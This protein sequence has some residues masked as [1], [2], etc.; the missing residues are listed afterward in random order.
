LAQ[1]N[2]EL[3]QAEAPQPNVISSIQQQR[4]QPDVIGGMEKQHQQPVGQ[5]NGSD[6]HHHL[7]VAGGG[8]QL[9]AEDVGH[10]SCTAAVLHLKQ[11]LPV[12]QQLM[13]PLLKLVIIQL[14]RAL[15]SEALI[16][17]V[18]TGCPMVTCL[19]MQLSNTSLV[20]TSEFCLFFIQVCG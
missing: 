16:W 19:R 3:P 15:R 20:F 7:I 5:A 6:A 13:L 14:F 9:P 10:A 18:G 8:V 1:L 11:I 4:Q 2:A 17:L 12:L